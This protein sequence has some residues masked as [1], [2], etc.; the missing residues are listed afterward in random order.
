MEF[1]CKNPLQCWTYRSLTRKIYVEIN[2]I[3]CEVLKYRRK[4]VEWY[5]QVPL[6]VQLFAKIWTVARA[7]THITLCN[8]SNMKKR[9]TNAKYWSYLWAKSKLISL[10][11]KW[12]QRMMSRSTSAT[13]T[14]KSFTH[15]KKKKKK[16]FEYRSTADCFWSVWHSWNSPKFNRLWWNQRQHQ[17]HQEKNVSSGLA[18]DVKSIKIQFMWLIYAGIWLDYLDFPRISRKKNSKTN[19]K[20]RI[21]NIK[22]KKFFCLSFFCLLSPPFQMFACTGFCSPRAFLLL[23]SSKK[24][25]YKKYRHLALRILHRFVEMMCASNNSI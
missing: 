5:V 14:P 2:L 3:H 16:K 15:I 23:F 4:T 11:E 7:R 6:F 19:R 25:K 9:F 18:Y 21:K 8:E 13:I 1:E 22:Y 24:K 12:G 17:K 10:T 20:I